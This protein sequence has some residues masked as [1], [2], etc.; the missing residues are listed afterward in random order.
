M[1]K[2]W[3]SLVLVG[4]FSV[5]L[6]ACGPAAQNVPQTPAAGSLR[7][8][9]PLFNLGSLRSL[10]CLINSNHQLQVGIGAPPAIP[11]GAKVSFI[12]KLFN[13]G[14][15]CSDAGSFCGAVT[16]R[17]PIQPHLF[18]TITGQPAFDDHSPCQ[19]WQELPPVATQ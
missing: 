6:G 5:G 15:N 10:A 12:A 1:L 4:L 11:V 18:T 2:P 16:L 3:V 19:A 9:P 17:D 13:Q 7:P 8:C 14:P